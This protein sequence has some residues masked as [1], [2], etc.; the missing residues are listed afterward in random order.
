M[1]MTNESSLPNKLRM[2]SL[3]SSYASG[4]GI[5]PQKS[6]VAMRSAHNF[7]TI[8]AEKFNAELTDLSVSG[9]T[10]GNV[11]N[12][13][14]KAWMG[15][16]KFPPQLDGLAPDTDVVLLTGGGNDLNYDNAIFR[17]VLGS[18]F[19]GRIWAKFIPLPGEGQDM[20]AEHL[21]RRFSDVIDAI[22]RKSPKAKIL[23]VEYFTLL[24][25]YTRP[26]IDVALEKGRMEYHKSISLKLQRA[27]EKAA[28][29][30]KN[31]FLIPVRKLSRDHGLGSEEPWLEGF[32]FR[33][34][35]SAK[36]PFHPNARGMQ[37]VADELYTQLKE[38]R[39][40]LADIGESNERIDE[41]EGTIVQKDEP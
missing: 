35:L 16:K 10:L 13:P 27:H 21:V 15:L 19:L 22:Q 8:L 39:M 9:A 41:E 5:R 7:A 12:E 37:A 3:G 31:V 17:D 33:M 18:K 26:G 14:Q 2:A 11:L 40:A 38:K 34:M 4:P 25:P 1:S 23:L 28:E 24:G 6:R 36:A 20:K 30:R 32:S 29:G